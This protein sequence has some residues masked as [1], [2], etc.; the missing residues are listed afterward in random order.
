MP[1]GGESNCTDAWC[2]SSTRV[3]VGATMT[4]GGVGGTVGMIVGCGPGLH[5]LA[6]DGHGLGG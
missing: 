2:P 5:S 3:D 4:G 1:L 6:P